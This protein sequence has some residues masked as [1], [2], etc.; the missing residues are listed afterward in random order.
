MGRKALISAVTLY[1][2]ISSEGYCLPLWFLLQSYPTF[3][4][5]KLLWKIS[6]TNISGEDS[7]INTHEGF[8]GFNICCSEPDSHF[9]Y[10][11][12]PFPPQH[13]IIFQSICK[14]EGLLKKKKK[15]LDTII[16]TST[17]RVVLP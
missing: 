4:L 7:L 13:E 5:K 10:S 11:P 17:V 9:I 12:T 1:C 16:P 14:R 6:C 8:T 15:A 2:R 3:F